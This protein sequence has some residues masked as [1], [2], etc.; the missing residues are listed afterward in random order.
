M[1]FGYIHIQRQLHFKLFKFVEYFLHFTD[2]LA[3]LEAYGALALNFMKVFY[4]KLKIMLILEQSPYTFSIV[5]FIRLQI[6]TK[7]IWSSLIN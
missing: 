6:K 3:Y 2:P 5:L 7:I 4:R 1:K